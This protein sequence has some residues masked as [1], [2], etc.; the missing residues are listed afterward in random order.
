MLHC[1]NMRLT[2]PSGCV[3][4]RATNPYKK[5]TKTECKAQKEVIEYV[6]VYI[7]TMKCKH[8]IHGYTHR[9]VYIY[10]FNHGHSNKYTYIQTNMD[11]QM[12][13]GH[14]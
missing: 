6:C 7:P 8:K 13:M 2:D 9:D 1:H 4:G 5:N 14:T 10:A 12:K 3:S 11:T